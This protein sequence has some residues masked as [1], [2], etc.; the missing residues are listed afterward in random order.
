[1]TTP[2]EV[3]QGVALLMASEVDTLDRADLDAI[4][5]VSSRVRS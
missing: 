4:V 2:S 5:A 3:L 1:M